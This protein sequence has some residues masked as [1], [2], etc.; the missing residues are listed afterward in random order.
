MQTRRERC[1]GALPRAAG[2]PRVPGIGGDGVAHAGGARAAVLVQAAPS[3]LR[4]AARG[5]G[6]LP[7]ARQP[8]GLP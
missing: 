1:V 7:G 5:A 6:L 8:P 3:A 2:V 4:A